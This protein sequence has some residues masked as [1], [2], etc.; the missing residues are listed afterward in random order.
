MMSCS[1][2]VSRS[3]WVLGKEPRRVQ[4]NSCKKI[5]CSCHKPKTR[6]EPPQSEEI[7]VI[8]SFVPRFGKVSDAIVEVC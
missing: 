6:C 2:L 5:L 7:F 1:S 8:G 3:R 4:P